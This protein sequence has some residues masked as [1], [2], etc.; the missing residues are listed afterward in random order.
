MTELKSLRADILERLHPQ[1][2]TRKMVVTP[3]PKIVRE[4]KAPKT[5]AVLTET[6]QPAIKKGTNVLYKGKPAKVET[7]N[8]SSGMATVKLPRRK[9]PIYVR[10]SDLQPTTLN[11]GVLGMVPI[12]FTY[13]EPSRPQMLRLDNLSAADIGL[14]F[15]DEDDDDEE[16]DGED[17]V[18]DKDGQEEDFDNGS[19]VR[20]DGHTGKTEVDN[21]PT[22]SDTIAPAYDDNTPPKEEGTPLSIEKGAEEAHLWDAPNWDAYDY[23]ADAPDIPSAD[24]PGEE[25]GNA[26]APDQ[27]H[28]HEGGD[29]DAADDGDSGVGDGGDDET[30]EGTEQDGRFGFISEIN[31][32]AIPPSPAPATGNN[33]TH[34]QT[35]TSRLMTGGGHTFTQTGEMNTGNA[36]THKQTTEAA[37]RSFKKL[38]AEMDDLLGPGEDKEPGKDATIT[39]TL[40]AMA[41]ICC[42]SRHCDENMLK[43]M[44]EALA[45]VGGSKTIDV[46][47]LEAVACHVNGEEA[48]EMQ[49]RE[50]GEDDHAG[51]E[52]DHGHLQ[53]DSGEGGAHDGHE[54]HGGDSDYE[55][56]AGDG[57]PDEHGKEKLFGGMGESY[58]SWYGSDEDIIKETQLSE[59]DELRLMKKRAGMKYW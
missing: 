4:S 17:E 36:P 49:N 24:F 15:E 37:V 40:P 21:L 38:I 52:T 25:M 44:I 30:N 32:A 6:P 29:D 5:A 13:V 48:P 56:P 39:V 31:P 16:H 54:D 14:M 45:E 55:A 57:E 18:E 10:T 41:S 50:D 1:A 23:P 34:M 22:P 12:G 59:E 7:I 2:K 20:H 8:E 11:E 28:Q 9:E 26:R 43:A 42:T 3:R 51:M 35:P 47:D 46:D 53:G 58:T 33:A 19:N 27:S